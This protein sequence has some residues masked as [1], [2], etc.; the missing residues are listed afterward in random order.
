MVNP[1]GRPTKYKQE[2]CDIVIECGKEGKTL[3]EMATAIDV[4]RATV[5]DWMENNQE[6]SRAVKHG[7]GNAQA[8]W[9]KQGRKRTFDSNGFNATSYIFQMK[10]RFKDDWRDKVE[11][12]HT[13]SDGSMSPVGEVPATERL[14]ALID[15]IK[16][17]AEDEKSG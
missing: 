1:V 15:A 6:F 4:D 2:M 10:N 17:K 12:D 5:N 3:A 9:E 13:S 8:W 16:P 7:L 11:N 14:A